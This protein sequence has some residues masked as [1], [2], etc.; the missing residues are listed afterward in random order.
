MWKCGKTWIAW[1]AP[2]VAKP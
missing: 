2:T 1:P